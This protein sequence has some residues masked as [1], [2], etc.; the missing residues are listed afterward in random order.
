MIRMSVLAIAFIALHFSVHVNAQF[1]PVYTHTTGG[2][3]GSYFEDY[4]EQ[5]FMRGIQVKSATLVDALGMICATGSGFPVSR[6]LHGGGGGYYDQYT[7][8]T[9]YVA[10]GFN[11]RSAR[12]ID[13]IQLI[14][15]KQS[16][17]TSVYTSTPSFGKNGGSYFSIWCGD[18]DAVVGIQGR[19]A[20]LLDKIGLICSRDPQ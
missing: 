16:N 4:C 20:R 6:P 12:L 9:G 1:L 3:G 15:V 7:C 18:L 5:G 19:S 17:M 14:C 10:K 2:N 11:G 8:P 13:K